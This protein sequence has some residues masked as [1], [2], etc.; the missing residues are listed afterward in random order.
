MPKALDLFGDQ[1]GRLTV[2]GPRVV[3]KR[4]VYWTCRCECGTETV[5]FSGSLRAGRTNSC[6]CLRSELTVT[7]NTTHGG[8]VRGSR[9]PEYGVWAF[10]RQRCMNPRD[11]SYYRYGGRGITVC[12]RW[13]AFEAFL[14]DMGPRPTPDH[15]IERIDN[16]GPYAPE[17]CRWATRTEQ[18]N[19]RRSSRVLTHDGQTHTATEWSRITGIGAPAIRVRIDRL[20]WSVAKALTTP[21]QTKYHHR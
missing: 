20:G 8:N 10:M 6:G 21:V 3:I 11:A 18:A 7:R 4:R 19:N 15:S 2:I 1:Y 5:V 14:G 16:D 17:N 9:S 13:A 12:D